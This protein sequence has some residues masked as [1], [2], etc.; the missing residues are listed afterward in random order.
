MKKLYKH[1]S[2]AIF[3]LLIIAFMFSLLYSGAKSPEFI[4]LDQLAKK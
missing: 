4:T 3:S 1:A 2:W